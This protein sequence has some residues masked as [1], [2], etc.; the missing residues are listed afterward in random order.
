M[1]RAMRVSALVSAARA[2]LRFARELDA[3]LQ[4]VRAQR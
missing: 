2:Q 4:K 1:L 3:K